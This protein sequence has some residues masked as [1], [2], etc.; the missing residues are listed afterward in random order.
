MVIRILLHAYR[1]RLPPAPADALVVLGTA[2]Y[3][4]VPSRQFAARLDHAVGLWEAGVAKQVYTLG[5]KLPGDRFTEAQVGRQ[6]LAD[7]GVA[8]TAV[9]EGNDTVGSYRALVDKHAPGRVII[10]TDPNHALRA[11]ILARQAGLEAVTSPTTTS[12]TRFPTAAWWRTLAHEMGG[13]AVV[14]VSRVLGRKRAD[15]LE[16]LLRRVESFLRPSRRARHAALAD[17]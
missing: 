17:K 2:Q 1:R 14:D 4:G 16:T 5:G 11:E 7:R 3:D 13:M 8:A 10:V 15:R 12:P 6:Y 9:P